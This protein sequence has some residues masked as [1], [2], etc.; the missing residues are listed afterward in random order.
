MSEAVDP[1]LACRDTECCHSVSRESQRVATLQRV[2]VFVVSSTK[3]QRCDLV[4][5]FLYVFIM[6]IRLP[7]QFN[8]S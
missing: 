2:E 7:I 4:L 6:T 1:V 5:F 8:A 3:E